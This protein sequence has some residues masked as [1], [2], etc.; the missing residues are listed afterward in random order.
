MNSTA[1]ALR[2]ARP[3]SDEG[4][5]FAGYLDTAADDFFRATL[6]RQVERILADA[7]QEK[8]LDLPCQLVTFAERGGQ[9]VGM[10]SDYTTEE[11]RRGSDEV[12]RQAAGTIR[13]T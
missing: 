3:T 9:I 12:L 8:G 1:P 11:H 10:A 2:P 13:T 7:Y 6:G 5:A 4:V